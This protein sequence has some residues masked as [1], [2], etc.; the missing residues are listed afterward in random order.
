[1][2]R[3]RNAQQPRSAG[4]PNQS[5]NTGHARPGSRLGAVFPPAACGCLKPETSPP[6]QRGVPLT[7]PLAAQMAEIL[8]SADVR[9]RPVEV[10]DEAALAQC[11][12][13]LG[14]RLIVPVFRCSCV[15]GKGLELLKR[16]LNCLPK[17]R[18]WARYADQPPLF[19]IDHQT[20]VAG[21]GLVV[22]G[23]VRRGTIAPGQRLLLG[24]FLD[25]SYRRVRVR[26]IHIHHS[27][28]Q[29]AAAGQAASLALRLSS[30]REPG[31][32]EVAASEHGSNPG[33]FGLAAAGDLAGRGT[34]LERQKALR[35][36][37]Q[38]EIREQK[39]ARLSAALQERERARQQAAERDR[40]QM[41]GVRKGMI[42][43]HPSRRPRAFVEFEV[44]VLVMNDGGRGLRSGWSP[45]LHVG[46]VVQAARAMS[47]RPPPG[48][49][50]KYNPAKTKDRTTA[51]TSATP[52]ARPSPSPPATEVPEAPLDRRLRQR[53]RSTSVAGEGGADD[54]DER[55]LLRTGDRALVR[56]RFLHRPEH[57]VV[58]A[59]VVA[60]DGS[61][62]RGIGRVFAL[63]F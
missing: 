54:E 47:I 58:G 14:Q 19:M 31:G 22:S 45:V 34:L 52:Q 46:T 8:T 59:K 7:F 20:Q 50:A 36:S 9:K 57:L 39:E 43:A 24:P 60:R 63:L 53:R 35:P 28:C 13:N 55:P 18:D 44:L 51:A 21:V 11:A 12:K 33:L 32:A 56:F 49:S 2:T 4:T 29:Q 16:F 5:S 15:S 62:T 1:M 25:G 42:L 41:G 37:L 38:R 10:R 3:F 40:L 61:S 30:E 26:S 27:P 17:L 23:L 6:L 48:D